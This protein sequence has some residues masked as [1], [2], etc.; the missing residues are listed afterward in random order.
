MCECSV[1]CTGCGERGR[2]CIRDETFICAFCTDG[3]AMLCYRCFPVKS[4]AF[5]P[6]WDWYCRRTASCESAARENAGRCCRCDAR[7][8]SHKYL[9][10]GGRRAMCRRCV[11][12]LR[13]KEKNL[14]RRMRRQKGDAGSILPDSASTDWDRLVFSRDV[15]RS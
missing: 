2:G 6:R 1:P 13:S 7:C 12:T 5:P 10:N 3:G 4:G 15:Q 14:R 9:L 8:V 11:F